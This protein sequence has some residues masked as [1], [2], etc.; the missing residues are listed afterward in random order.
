MGRTKALIEINDVTLLARSVDVLIAG[1]CDPVAVITGAD[2][3]MVAD[4]VPAHAVPI[5]NPRWASGMASSVTA[6]LR[7][8]LSGPAG[9]LLILPVDTPGIGAAVIWRL[10]HHWHE[11]GAPPDG[12]LVATYQGRQR[13]PAL[14]GRDHW[15]DIS[16]SVTGDAGARQWLAAHPE[17]VTP[18]ACGDIADPSDLDTPQDLARWTQQ[19]SSTAN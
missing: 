15:S 2:G 18:V 11:T 13:N 7:W 16:A 4:V 1:G 12:V 6:A 5:H 3:A 10:V 14:I 9:A 19:A 17:A 8:A